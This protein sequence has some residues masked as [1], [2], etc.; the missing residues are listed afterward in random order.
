MPSTNGHKKKRAILYTRVSGDEQAKKGYSLPDQNDALREWAKREGYEVLEEI[1]DGGYSGAYL[2]RPG[3]DRVRDLVAAGGVSVVAVLFRDRLARGV[4]AQLLKAEFAEHGTGFVALNAQ[5]DD[6]P[7]GELQGGILDQFVA[8]E[9]AKIAERSRRG[10]MRKAR[11]GKIVAG[12]TPN[13][14]FGYNDKRDNYVVNEE[15]MARVRR[16]FHMIGVEGLPLYSAKRA[17]ERE[18]I[19][20][21]NGGKHWAKKSIRDMILD[22]VYRPHTYEEVKTQVSPDVAAP[23]DPE[24]RYGIWWFNRRRT[25]RK[26]VAEPNGDGGRDYK[27]RQKVAEKPREEWIAVPVPDSGVPRE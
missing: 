25:T 2:E 11:E 22:D 21:P 1:E 24:K 6:S 20:A 16:A 19:P 27:K 14:G 8:Y 4:Y 5:L 9:R 23:L 10:K 17:F 3:L 18:G 13:Y 15:T 12:H 7:E 26:Q